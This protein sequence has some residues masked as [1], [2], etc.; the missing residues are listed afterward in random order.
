MSHYDAISCGAHVIS[1]ELIGVSCASGGTP[2]LASFQQTSSSHPLRVSR[3]HARATAALAHRHHCRR[4]AAAR[5]GWP[6]RLCSRP[7]A[8]PNRRLHRTYP[9]LGSAT[10]RRVEGRGSASRP[11]PLPA[12]SSATSMTSSMASLR[13]ARPLLAR[14]SRARPGLLHQARVADH[15][16]ADARFSPV[17][18][19]SR[20]ATQPAARQQSGARG[21]CAGGEWRR[22]WRGGR[23]GGRCGG[24]RG[25]GRGGR[26]CV[27]ARF[28][29]P[30]AV[31][32][33]HRFGAELDR[34]RRP[35]SAIGAL[36]S[37]TSSRRARRVT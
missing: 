21:R 20:G 22:R 15:S 8:P 1:S 5:L 18:P 26:R 16:A 17:L 4:A 3:H 27:A 23:R 10:F 11:S 34:A 28:A 13:R 12:W 2:G 33:K 30:R 19:R 7:D 24:R 32:P 9:R 6:A 14:H 29:D 31:P 36:V 25:G 35:V 37:V